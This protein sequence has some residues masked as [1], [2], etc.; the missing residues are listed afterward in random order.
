MGEG[1]GRHGN[2]CWKRREEEMTA[3]AGGGGNDKGVKSIGTEKM[4]RD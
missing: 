3:H 2:G 4:R 1:E